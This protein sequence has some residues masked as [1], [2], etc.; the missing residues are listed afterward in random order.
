[1]YDYEA[2]SG[3]DGYW[4]GVVYFGKD[5]NRDGGTG[6]GS[7]YVRSNN[8]AGNIDKYGDDLFITVASKAFVC[9]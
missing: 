5:Q 2:W 1:M 9:P 4:I 3:V 7:A 8:P 6:S